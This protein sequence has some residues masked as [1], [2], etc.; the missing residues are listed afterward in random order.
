VL[1]DVISANESYER[2]CARALRSCI[3]LN[4]ILRFA[5]YRAVLIDPLI[6][7]LVNNGRIL[8]ALVDAICTPEP[9]C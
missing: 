1:L 2:T 3:I 9:A 4:S 7:L 6:R 8:R 5:I